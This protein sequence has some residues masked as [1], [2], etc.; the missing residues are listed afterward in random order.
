[1]AVEE[2]ELVLEERMCA[3]YSYNWGPNGTNIATKE[4]CGVSIQSNA[5]CNGTGGFFWVRTVG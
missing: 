1:M 2:I 4:A 5:E 3:D